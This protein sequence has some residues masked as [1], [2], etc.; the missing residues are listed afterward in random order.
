[1]LRVYICKANYTSATVTIFMHKYFTV[2]VGE[3]GASSG[4]DPIPECLPTTTTTTPSPSPI[5][6]PI[7][8]SE[9]GWFGVY[10]SPRVLEL[11]WPKTAIDVPLFKL[12][13]SPNYFMISLTSW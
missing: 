4:L 9:P 5:P 8:P 6:T 11:L 2:T 10:I 7:H 13:L 12:I 1:M 3:N